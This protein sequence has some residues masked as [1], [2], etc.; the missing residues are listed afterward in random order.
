MNSLYENEIEGIKS[1]ID[2]KNFPH[3]F[4]SSKTN[5]ITQEQLELRF[6]ALN[7]SLSNQIQALANSK[8][9]SKL[10]EEILRELKDIKNSFEEELKNNF[11]SLNER[12]NNGE[13]ILSNILKRKT[14][15]ME[16]IRD[17]F[18]SSLDHQGLQIQ[19]D[20]RHLEQILKSKLDSN[21]IKGM[22]ESK[23]D[24]SAMIY[25][26]KVNLIES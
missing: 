14:Q 15:V 6:K 8:S 7:Q 25:E 12:V 10:N 26:Y 22:M 1:I 5:E 16:R 20:I 3:Q 24:I 21:Q 23:S 17:D 18:V 4:E 9:K 2:S 19:A 13:E 11:N